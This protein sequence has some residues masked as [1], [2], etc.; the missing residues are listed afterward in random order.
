MLAFAGVF[1]E[2]GLGLLLP[3]M[4]PDVIGEVYHYV[5]SLHEVLIGLG[6]WAT[7]ALVY[8]L[9]LKVAIAISTG[10]FRHRSAGETVPLPSS[11]RF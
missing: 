10:E 7:G 5:P 11:S 9:M 4:T 2:K 8:T 3:G 6:V 1:I